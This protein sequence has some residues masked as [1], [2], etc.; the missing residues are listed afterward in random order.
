MVRNTKEKEQKTLKLS[1]LLSVFVVRNYFELFLPFFGELFLLFDFEA[2]F[3]F[4]TFAL[5]I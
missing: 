2:D 5:A 4:D 3:D 1:A